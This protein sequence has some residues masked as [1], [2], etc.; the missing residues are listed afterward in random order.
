LILGTIGNLGAEPLSLSDVAADN[1]SVTQRS[2][3]Q[4]HLNFSISR[5]DT[6]LPRKRPIRDRSSITKTPYRCCNNTGHE[7]TRQLQ[8]VHIMTSNPNNDEASN[9]EAQHVVYSFPDDKAAPPRRRRKACLCLSLL[10]LTGVIV[11]LAVVYSDSRKQKTTVAT[12]NLEAGIDTVPEET[13]AE[14][15]APTGFDVADAP[16]GA[17]PV[18]IEEVE[19]TV[20]TEPA[21]SAVVAADAVDAPTAAETA[22]APV[23]SPVSPV[24]AAGSAPVWSPVAAEGSAPVWSPVSPVASPDAFGAAAAPVLST[25]ASSVASPESSPVASPEAS[26]VASPDAAPSSPVA[27]VAAGVEEERTAPPAVPDELPE[28]EDTATDFPE[29]EAADETNDA[30]EEK[31]DKN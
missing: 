2:F 13:A 16:S 8:Q 21:P 18:A 7:Y 10:T 6:K 26:P 19:G 4:P 17:A 29:E 12:S 28:A 20:A 5:P 23:W 22:E 9:V 11:A 14:P 24:A 1:E 15:V 25:D 30:P 31:E 3:V 27:A